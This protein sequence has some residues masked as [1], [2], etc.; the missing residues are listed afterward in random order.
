MRDNLAQQQF[1]MPAS[2]S[3]CLYVGT[4]VGWFAVYSSLEI[5]GAGGV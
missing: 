3:I 4:S 1:Y 5:C 2:P